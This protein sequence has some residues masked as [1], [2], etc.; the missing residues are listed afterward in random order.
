M[1]C[2]SHPRRLSAPRACRLASA[3]LASGLLAAGCGGGSNSP[4]VA[5]A[6]LTTT[7]T[8][9]SAAT[10]SRSGAA[11]TTPKG[12]PTQL[13]LEWAN[14]M[15]SHGDPD[16]ADPTVT[17]GKVIDI[18]WN[19]ATPGGY[20][21]T[22]KGGRGNS[23]PGQFCRQYLSAAQTGLRGGRPFRALDPA[24]LV[25][26]SECMRANGVPDFPDPTASGELILPGNPGQIANDPTLQAASKLCA[27]K[28][29]VRGLDVGGTPQPG[30]IAL[31]GAGG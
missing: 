27:K 2:S 9:S 24:T 31:S 12:S 14:C 19:P 5:S 10:A 21:G 28:V 30:T 11:T 15:R 17:A 26:F 7:S 3:A 23:G 18:P 25:R 8:T 29:G 20:Y 6:G 13:L 4:S 1:R 16:Q 22:F